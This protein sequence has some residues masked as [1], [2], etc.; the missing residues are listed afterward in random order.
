MKLLTLVFL[1]ILSLTAGCTGGGGSPPP[2]IPTPTL[3]PVPQPFRTQTTFVD[4]V[5]SVDVRYHG[6]RTRTLDTDRHRDG[7]WGLY[8]PRPLQ[9]G[10]ISRE[11]ILSENHYDGRIVLYTCLLY[12][13]PSPR[14][15]LLSRMP[16][17][18]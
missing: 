6:G 11:S 8:L 14:D 10:H 9:P 3:T 17:S 16:S 18:A 12:T 15:G 5:L 4:N 13:S 2:P 1:F 7:S